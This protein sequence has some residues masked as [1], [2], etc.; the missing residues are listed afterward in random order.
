MPALSTFRLNGATV[1]LD[2]AA[3]G[4]SLL[5]WL[6][7]RHV[8]G[9]KEGCADGDCG[10]CS[11]VLVE[12]GHPDGPRYAAVNSCLLPLGL[13][14]GR[15]VLTVEALADGERLHPVQSAL[16]DCAGSQCGYC[17]PGFVM[18]LFAG[19]YSRELDDATTEGNLC[20]CT[21]YRPI[22]AATAALDAMPAPDDRFR[23]LL[24]AP[25]PPSPAQA[26]P[27][28]H[29]P[30][31][32][33]EALALKA[34]DPD[35]MW[36][37]GATDLG[38]ALSHHRAPAARYIALDRIDALQVLEIDDAQVRIGAAVPLSRVEVALH[39]IFPALDALL[40]AFAA[41]QVKNRATLGGN[42]GTASPIGDLLPLLLALD[43]EIELVGPRGARML[44]ADG[45]FL[46]YRHTRRA[47]DELIRAVL[48][49]RRN[50]VAASGYKVAK[51]QT[52][53]ISIVAA[54]FALQLDDGGRVSHARLAYGGMAAVPL[55]ARRAEALLQGRRLDA[56]TVDAVCIALGAEFEPLSDHRASADYRR[57]LA[58]NLFRRHVEERGA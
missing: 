2:G 15:E 52:D 22:R 40:H 24:D 36:V 29:V 9:T 12:R 39:G 38:V 3:P 43:A 32:V 56:A 23:R 45:Y 44:P 17:T 49:P 13:L 26:L 35:A 5:R 7:G 4:E 55:R 33:D 25:L 1:A 8:T 37:A 27:G 54:V 19:Y 57:A 31:T 16:V 11:V 58:A 18:S 34:A 46:G 14:P 30:A 6:R 48:L 50:G 47:A 41:R 42:L 53:D 10:A 51:R 21:G 28:F 20:R